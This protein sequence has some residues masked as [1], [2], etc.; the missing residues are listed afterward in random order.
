M[1]RIFDAGSVPRHPDI[2]GALILLEDAG[3]NKLMVYDLQRFLVILEFLDVFLT[4]HGF[5]E[6]LFDLLRQLLVHGLRTADLGARDLL[7]HLLCLLIFEFTHGFDPCYLELM[8]F[9][10]FWVE[11]RFHVELGMIMLIDGL[12]GLGV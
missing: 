5:I 2:V 1:L 4:P 12:N 3:G 7:V 6:I 9:S 10:Y 8:I 11:G